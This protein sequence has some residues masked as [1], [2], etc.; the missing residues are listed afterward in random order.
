MIRV[1]EKQ[2]EERIFQLYRFGTCYVRA[3]RYQCI[4]RCTKGKRRLHWNFIGDLF[5][6]YASKTKCTTW[7]KQ[8]RQFNKMTVEAV[9]N[10]HSKT[11]VIFTRGA[12]VR[13]W[14]GS[15]FCVSYRWAI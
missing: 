15:F 6:R 13:D 9:E 14:I 12:P 1:A 3:R 2:N 11:S 8:K 7:S 10:L 5:K 4:G